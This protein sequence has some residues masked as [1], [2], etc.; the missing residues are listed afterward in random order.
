MIIKDDSKNRN[1]LFLFLKNV[2]FVKNTNEIFESRLIIAED[3]IISII[4][5]SSGFRKKNKTRNSKFVC[6][7]FKNLI[8]KNIEVISWLPKNIKYR[9]SMIIASIK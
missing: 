5:T 2:Y 6:F 1:I 8:N 4:M 9:I 3:P 7:N